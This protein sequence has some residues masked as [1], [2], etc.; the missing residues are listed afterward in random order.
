MSAL[1]EHFF[2]DAA[3]V[4]RLRAAFDPKLFT[5][6]VSGALRKA[7][8]DELADLFRMAAQPRPL[9]NQA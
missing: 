1:Q 8:A 7:V 2:A 9:E 3:H 5:S 6:A 4:V